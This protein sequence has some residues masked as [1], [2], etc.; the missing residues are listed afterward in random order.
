MYPKTFIILFHIYCA[1]FLLCSKFR[2]YCFYHSILKKS[3]CKAPEFA[4]SDLTLLVGRREEHLACK[5]LSDE[6]LAWL[7]VWTGAKCK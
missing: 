1:Y 2:L 6:L 3:T 5:K 4:F 7:Y